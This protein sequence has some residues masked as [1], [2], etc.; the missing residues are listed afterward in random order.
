MCFAFPGKIIKID[1][2]IATINYQTEL[3][4]AKLI[5]KDNY[6]VNDFV[7]VQAGII[8]QK[9]PEQQALENL[10]LYHQA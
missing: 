7:I 9:I 3:R 4:T 2:D 6:K 10:H 1:N 5:D 8:V